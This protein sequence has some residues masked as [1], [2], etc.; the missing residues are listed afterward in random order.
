MR[1]RSLQPVAQSAA[2][3]TPR[4]L[5]FSRVLT[6]EMVFFREGVIVFHAR[7]TTNDQTR[8]AMSMSLV[9]PCQKLSQIA[10]ARQTTSM[11]GILPLI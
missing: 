6:C 3:N 1:T 8:I 9:A 2:L 7:L 11:T 5:T 4:A 10:L